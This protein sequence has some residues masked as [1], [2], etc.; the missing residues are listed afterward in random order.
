MNW[1]LRSSCNL[2]HSQCPL[3]LGTA[4]F[5]AHFVQCAPLCVYVLKSSVHFTG[6]IFCTNV[7]C[8]TL[9]CALVSMLTLCTDFAVHCVLHC[10]LTFALCSCRA[11]LSSERQ[12]FV[13]SLVSP[14]E[15]ASWTTVNIIIVIVIVIIIIIIIINIAIIMI[16]Y[17]I[18]RTIIIPS[19]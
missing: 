15:I 16:F 4:L 1:L 17:L 18:V 11:A 5:V 19:S 14:T 6:N 2:G 12:I 13:T 9:H 7:L 3:A 8:M 10:A